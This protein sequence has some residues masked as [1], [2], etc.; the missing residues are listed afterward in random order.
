MSKVNYSELQVKKISKE[1]RLAVYKKYDGHCAYCGRTLTLGQ[2]QVDHGRPQSYPRRKVDIGEVGEPIFEDLNDIANLM[3][4]CRY[5]NNYKG[6][7]DINLF[8]MM[9][10]NLSAN[11]HLIF[12]SRAKA[13]VLISFGIVTI[14][15]WDEQFYFE[16]SNS[17]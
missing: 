5:C 10:K 1:T 7:A 16:K 15:P 11:K 12:A 13:E 9:I 8:R 3:P 14:E 2:M 6:G 17:R 4:A